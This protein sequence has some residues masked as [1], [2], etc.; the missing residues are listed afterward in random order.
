MIK[1]S[2]NNRWVT[3]ENATSP[4]VN[5]NIPSIVSDAVTRLVNPPEAPGNLLEDI[6]DAAKA[7]HMEQGAEDSLPESLSIPDS[8]DTVVGHHED[9]QFDNRIA[10]LLDGYTIIPGRELETLGGTVADV[11]YY[12]SGQKFDVFTQKC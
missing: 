10:S 11:K 6:A 5:I 9:F 7:V 8:N 2:D 12:L 1:H 4:V 3:I